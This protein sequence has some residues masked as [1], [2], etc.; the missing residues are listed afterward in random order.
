MYALRKI[1]LTWKPGVTP[2]ELAGSRLWWHGPH[3]LRQD[4]SQW[5]IRDSVPLD[6]DIELRAVKVHTTFFSNYEDVAHPAHRGHHV[7]HST[8]LTSSE[9][10]N[11]RLRLAIL[12]QKAYY[13]G[14][15]ASLLRKEPIGPKSSLLP[16]NPFLDESGVLRLNGRLAR[17]P[18]L[19]YSERHPIIV[20]YNSRFAALLA[21]YVHLIS[22]HGGNQLMLRIL[23]IEY[24]VPR[25]T[26]LVRKT[27]NGCKRCLLDRKRSCSQIMAAL[28]PER[29]TLSR[30]FATTGVDFAGPFEVKSFIGRACKVTKS[31]VCVF[32]CFSTKAIHLEATSDLSTTSFLAAFYRFVSRRG[33]PGTIFSDNGTNFVGA[34][35]EIERDFKV[36]L[37]E[38]RDK[39]C[40]APLY[41]ELSWQFIPVGAPHMGGLWEAA[42]KSFKLHFLKQAN[43][44][45]Y[46]PHDIVALTP[47]HFLVGSSIVAP[48]EPVI[49]ESPLHIVNRYRKMKALTQQFC[50]R[51]NDEYL[52][53]LHK[54]YKWQFPQRDMQKDDLVVSR[55]EQLPPTSWKLSRIVDIHQG[56][57]G[58]VRVADVKTE[59]GVIRRPVVKL[60]PLTEMENI[61]KMAAT[62]PDFEDDVP[63][64]DE[65][66]E[67]DPTI[68]PL[69][70]VSTISTTADPAT[71]ADLSTNKNPLSTAPGIP[72]G[73]LSVASPPL[74]APVRKNQGSNIQRGRRE[75]V[76]C[77][78]KH[79]LRDCKEFRAMRIER[80]LRTVALHKC[81]GNCLDATHFVRDCPSPHR[82]KHCNGDHHTMLHN[83]AKNS[84]VRSRPATNSAPSKNPEF[85]QN[86]VDPLFVRILRLSDLIS[87]QLHQLPDP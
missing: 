8:A 46:T 24:W 56:T 52:K 3:W 82:C 27:I 15:Y 73:E 38:S 60:V 84:A 72:P 37:R 81:C 68:A 58:R 26:S 74:S 33:C 30:P 69:A 76:I 54:R 50:L 11:V 18:T 31:Y 13:A 66:R 55:H 9:L 6:T 22:I 10:K 62:L 77:K 48:A 53:S 63:M 5:D 64:S 2:S 75:C 20:P 39:L 35:R 29:T 57:D 59:N 28:P 12:A 87:R 61:A 17:S 67:I 85:L 1:P 32:V 16:L 80:R 65:E 51:W 14:E 49:D 44:F 40:S 4:R 45:K 71:L 47:G 25:L 34:S 41:Q 86:L 42:V 36:V 70:D 78:A 7:Y 19:A 21:R 23:R 79:H 43:G 83:H